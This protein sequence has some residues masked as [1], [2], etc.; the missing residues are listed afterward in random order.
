MS[1]PN[2]PHRARARYRFTGI[3]AKASRGSLSFTSVLP[4]R[5]AFHQQRPKLDNEHDNENEN[6]S[7]ERIPERRRKNK[8]GRITV[9]SPVATAQ[10]VEEKTKRAAL[11]IVVHGFVLKIKSTF[12][13]ERALT[14][15][16]NHSE[17]T[18]LFFL[19]SLLVFPATLFVS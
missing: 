7:E 4:P 3:T 19:F 12:L 16:V 9:P 1:R 2:L 10:K 18:F 11:R 17:L 13:P 14:D 5:R 15:R 6:D 8:P